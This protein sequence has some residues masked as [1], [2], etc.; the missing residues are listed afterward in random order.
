[1]SGKKKKLALD[2]K[3]S[4]VEF[5][6]KIS[7]I[8]T[9]VILESWTGFA[10][11]SNSSCRSDFELNMKTGLQTPSCVGDK[12]FLLPDNLSGLD[13][14][15]KR[16]QILRGFAGDMMIITKPENLCWLLN[17]RAA[18]VE[19]TPLLLAYGILFKNGEVEIFAEEKRARNLDLPKV[20]FI[21]PDCFDLRISVLRKKF[22]KVQ[23]DSNTTNQWLYSQLEK[24]NFEI[25]S[26]K[27]PIEILKAQKNSAEISGAIKAHEADGLALV[28]FLFWLKNA[29]ETDEIKAAEKLLE[30]RKE[31]PNFLYPS[32]ATIAGFASNGAVI[33]YRATEE[34]NKKIF[35]D[36][37]LSSRK[38][39]FVTPSSCS[40][41]NQ[42]DM[43]C[44]TE[45][46]TPSSARSVE[47]SLFLIDSGGQYFGED[48]CGTTDVTRTIAIGKP[49][50]EMIENFTR[51]LKGHIALATA[52]FPAGTSGA[53]LDALARNF[54]WQA[55]L[56]YDH[57]TGHGVGS[58]LSVHEGPQNISRRGHQPLLPGMIIS[59]EPGFYAE[60]KYGI[61]IE[62]LML[63]EKTE[64]NF[65]QFRTLT[66][67]PL[68][69]DLIDF[70][71][72]EKREKEW[73]YFYH[74]EIFN[75]LEPR[76][77][78]SEREWLKKILKFFKEK[79]DS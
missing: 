77:S 18:D 54:L 40:V 35:G 27:D 39:G 8:A 5:V 23:I 66:L 2:P 59:N 19:F 44:W 56:D 24:N 4:S 63:V 71:M 47:G 34:T 69:Q 46:Q 65:L 73:L 30:L 11:P 7:E 58:F 41:Q 10:T 17:I 74:Q 21:Q 9:P 75:T 31:N 67:A 64:K 14:K 68:D 26:K 48:F 15:T 52:K 79:N 61:R 57:G 76:L 45:L 12:I 51:V 3:L 6:K 32:F 49:S 42:T 36:G 55:G 1:M 50:A 16:S 22:K 38:T 33:H 78:S 29:G 70:A 13:S 28:K 53:Q 62:N 60:G 43:N 37:L 20:K 25:I 72:L